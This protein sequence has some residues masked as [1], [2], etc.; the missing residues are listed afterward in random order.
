MLKTMGAKIESRL[1]AEQLAKEREQLRKEIKRSGIDL[2]NRTP[3]D[4]QDMQL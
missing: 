3:L 4:I 2:P 1:E